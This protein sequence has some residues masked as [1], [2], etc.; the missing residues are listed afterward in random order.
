MFFLASCVDCFVY[1]H[2]RVLCRNNIIITTVTVLTEAKKQVR[3]NA[4]FAWSCMNGALGT[5][6]PA[7]KMDRVLYLKNRRKRLQSRKR[8]VQADAVAITARSIE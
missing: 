3:N 5:C 8:I 6:I 7:A 2:M 1:V 4:R